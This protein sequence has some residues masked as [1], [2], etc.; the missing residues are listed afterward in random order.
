MSVIL[1]R[2]KTKVFNSFFVFKMNVKGLFC[3]KAWNIQTKTM[4]TQ[5]KA[6]KNTKTFLKYIEKNRMVVFTA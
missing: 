1:Q 3:L 4:L 5:V 2:Q 6:F